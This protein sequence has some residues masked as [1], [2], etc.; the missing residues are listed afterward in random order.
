MKRL[1]DL[2]KLDRLDYLIRRAATGTP[3]ELAKRL[4]MSRSSLFEL[5]TF[6]KEDMR[7]P[8]VYIRS[9]P[10]YVYSYTP[11]FYLGF[12]RERMNAADMADT[13][14]GGEDNEIKNNFEC[15]RLEPDE[16]TNTFGGG[17]NEG[18][19]KK[20]KVEIEIN[21]DDCILDDDI[22]FNDLYQ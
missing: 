9:R 13:Y 14:G 17:I 10:S 22:D 1:V 11:Q 3:E 6:L 18:K 15:E 2:I 7:A 8:I 12:E 4:E 5:I 21:D 20:I 19:K 16:M